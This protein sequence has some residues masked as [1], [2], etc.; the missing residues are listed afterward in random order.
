MCGIERPNLSQYNFSQ[1]L[2]YSVIWLQQVRTSH[3]IDKSV[4]WYDS[5]KQDYLINSTLQCELNQGSFPSVCIGGN[6]GTVLELDLNMNL[7]SHVI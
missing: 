7:F 1:S 3:A 4:Q 6:H 2:T 5:S